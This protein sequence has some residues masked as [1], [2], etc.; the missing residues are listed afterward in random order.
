MAEQVS[1]LRDAPTC[2]SADW[3]NVHRALPEATD[4]ADVPDRRVA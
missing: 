4:P 1:L 2:G 3:Q